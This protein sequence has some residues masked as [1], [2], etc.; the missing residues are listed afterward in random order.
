MIRLLYI[1]D[2]FHLH[3]APKQNGAV[4]PHR[5]EVDERAVSGL[6][7]AKVKWMFL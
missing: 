7:R 2:L 1:V 6:A 4:P 5:P 3:C